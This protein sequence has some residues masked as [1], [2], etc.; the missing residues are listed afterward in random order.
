MAHFNLSALPTSDLSLKHLKNPRLLKEIEKTIRFS[1]FRLPKK[2]EEMCWRLL[3]RRGETLKLLK[4][5]CIWAIWANFLLGLWNW[6]CLGYLVTG[7]GLAAKKIGP[8]KFGLGF[9]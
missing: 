3:R 9:M 5:R 4:S 2:S 7:S 1:S 6:V 8:V